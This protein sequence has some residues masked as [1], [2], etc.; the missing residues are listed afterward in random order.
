MLGRRSG[1]DSLGIFNENPGTAAV[2]KADAVITD[3]DR[4]AVAVRYDPAT[5][6]APIVV[7]K[8]SG[9]FAIRI[10]ELATENDVPLV[11]R[12]ELAQR[13]SRD[14]AINSVVTQAMYADVAALLA[15]VFQAAGK[16]LADA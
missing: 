11:D 6:T 12:P 13:L 15:E 14:V 16:T 3:G 2:V 10:R 8:G 7:A 4:I 1:R 5:M 9:R